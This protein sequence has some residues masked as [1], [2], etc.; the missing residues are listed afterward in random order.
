MD[1]GEFTNGVRSFLSELNAGAATVDQLAP[2]DNLFDLGLVTSFTMVRLLVFVQRFT[3]VKLDIASHDL[4]EFY[5]VEGLHRLVC[6]A[7]A[8]VEASQ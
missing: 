7:A 6:Q 4:S 3:G 1:R 5:T 8:V 2:T